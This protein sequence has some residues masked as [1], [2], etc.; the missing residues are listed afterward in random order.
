VD[1]INDGNKWSRVATG[2]RVYLQGLPICESEL[3]PD[4]YGGLAVIHLDSVLFTAV[5]PDRKALYDKDVQIPK[6]KAALLEFQRSRLIQIKSEIAPV[7]FAKIY[8]K[9]TSDLDLAHLLN[10]IPYV[11]SGIFG[12]VEAVRIQDAAGDV[13]R[14]IDKGNNDDELIS[15]E[16]FKSG[17]IKAVKNCPEC[18]TDDPWAPTFL[19]LMQSAGAWKCLTSG[20]SDEHWVFQYIYD[21]NELTFDAVVDEAN[22]KSEVFYGQYDTSANISL[23]TRVTL[24]ARSALHKNEIVLT[25]QFENDWVLVPLTFDDFGCCTAYKCW[26][27]GAWD[28]IDH[29]K[30]ALHSYFDTENGAYLEDLEKSN[31]LEWKNKVSS[32]RNE[33]MILSVERTIEPHYLNFQED[34]M[35]EIGF[36]KLEAKHRLDD[37]YDSFSPAFKAVDQDFIQ[38]LKLALFLETNHKGITNEQVQRALLMVVQPGLRVGGPLDGEYIAQW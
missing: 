29:P 36:V 38:A 1:G 5:M 25:S 34:Q 16:R 27:I 18:A 19:K 21:F 9:H 7:E 15:I 2:A 22:S 12:Q 3:L 20:L 11:S 35:A 30:N 31:E 6:I 4:A 23:A 37:K 13:Y 32:L 10:D 8:W 24:N 28:R 33:H 14:Y 26:L 17:E